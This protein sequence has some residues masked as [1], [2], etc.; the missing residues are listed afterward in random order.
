[1]IIKP[2][3]GSLGTIEADYWELG[4]EKTSIVLMDSGYGNNTNFLQKSKK[5][6][7]KYIG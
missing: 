6:K 5:R 3:N 1:L 2:K 4:S 7:L